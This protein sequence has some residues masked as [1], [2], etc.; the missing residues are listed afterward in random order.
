MCAAG[1]D[2]AARIRA[3]LDRL[4]GDLPRL[5]VAV[6]GGGDSIALMHVIAEWASGRRQVRVATVDHGLRPE[7]ADEA[8]QVAQAASVL[9]LP[10]DRLPWRHGGDLPGNLM[11]NARNA[12]LMLMSEWAGE[13]GL[14]AIA[15]GH[16][17]DDQAETLLMRLMRGAGIDGLA[18]MAERR[19]AMGICWLRPMLRVGRA[20]LR[21]WL[22][23][24]GIGWIDDPSNENADFD[25]V[26]IRQA[27]AA[28]GITPDALARSA[29]N[30]R[31]AR[32]ALSHYT[33]QAA[34]GAIA[35]NG[36]LILPLAPIR[37]APPEI[38]RRLLIAGC[39]WIT[40]ADYPPRRATVLHAMQAVFSGGRVTLNGML[41]EPSDDDLRFCREPA[42]A[43]RAG[44]SRGPTWDNRW[45]ITGLQPHEHVAALGYAPLSGL[46]WRA[47]G[48][49]RDEAAASPAVWSGGE[50]RAAPLLEPGKTHG[51]SPLRDATHLPSLLMAH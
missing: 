43:L 29:E 18:G 51:I 10:H 5:G 21:E 37:E 45:K 15:L 9:G 40:G 22:T 6:S 50:L 48:L 41:I 46:D 23:G 17:E 31:D 34:A 36:S 13:Q 27:M 35:R 8:A 32:A 47:T 24:R 49:T 30:L 25:R 2:P 14:P 39:R 26:R 1:T 3:A 4:A 28:F 42:A 33:A 19:E 38:A 16:T 11:A 44:S 12:R 20:E 7:S